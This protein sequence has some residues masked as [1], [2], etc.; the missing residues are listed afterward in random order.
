MSNMSSNVFLKA[1]GDAGRRIHGRVRDIL[2]LFRPLDLVLDFP[3]AGQVLIK[4]LPVATTKLTLEGNRVVAD[5]VEDRLLL[6]TAELEVLAGAHPASR[7]QR[8]VRRPTGDWP[9]A[10]GAWSDCSRPG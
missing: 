5:K 7:R 10:A 9:P 3:D 6:F 1:G 2:E 8:G 4:L